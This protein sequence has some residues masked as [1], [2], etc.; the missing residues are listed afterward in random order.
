MKC[1]TVADVFGGHKKQ[2]A[3]FVKVCSGSIGTIVAV[4]N[5]IDDNQTYNLV[6]F[7]IKNSKIWCKLASSIIEITDE[8]NRKND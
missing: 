2:K 7:K 6:V 4:I 5:N 1:K 8:E 3:G